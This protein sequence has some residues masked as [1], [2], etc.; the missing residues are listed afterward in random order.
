MGHQSSSGRFPYACH[1]SLFVVFVEFLNSG[2][3][4][5]ICFRVCCSVSLCDRSCTGGS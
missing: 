4:F 5:F 2:L 1:V 3:V